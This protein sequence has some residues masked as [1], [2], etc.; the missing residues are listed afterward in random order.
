MTNQQVKY[1]AR[2]I[3]NSLTTIFLFIMVFNNY[4]M[5]PEKGVILVLLIAAYFW[6]M[7]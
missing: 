1:I 5:T 7:S 3:R 2:V 4:A 6:S